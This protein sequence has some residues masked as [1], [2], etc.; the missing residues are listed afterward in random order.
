MTTILNK[1]KIKKPTLILIIVVVLLA[2]PGLGFVLWHQNAQT[3]ASATETGYKTAQVRRG[4]LTLS[5]TGSGTLAA[6]KQVNLAF[7]IAGKV[8]AVNVQV[9]DT[10]SAGEPLAGLEDVSSLD[11]GLATAEL[12]LKL[13]KRELEDL[14]TNG[15]AS[16][17]NAQL[18]LANAEKAV[19]DAKAAL[20]VKG[21]ARC[22]QKTI[23][24]YY[25]VYTRAVDHLNA[26]GDGGGSQD[27]YLSVIV[28]AKNQVSKAYTTYQYCAGF[29]DYEIDSSHANLTLAQATVQQ[30]KETL[31]VLQENGGVDPDQLAQAEYKVANA[32]AAY[33]DAKEKREGAALRA[34]FDGTVLSVAGQAG[35]EVGVDTFISLADLNHPEIDFS[36]D[37][38]DMDQ[39]SVGN[40]AMVV[41]DAM[42]SQTFNGRVVRVNPSLVT[43]GGYQVLQGVIELDLSAEKTTPR[44]L[45]GLSASVEIIGGEAKNAVLAPV[46]AIHDLGDDVYGVF[47][48]GQDGKLRL[49][50]VEVGLMDATYAEIKS[51]LSAGDIVSTGAMETK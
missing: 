26:L 21:M 36:V 48:I 17:A 23:D 39:V 40:R 12:D 38:T 19:I 8:A 1:Q 31:S 51:G 32:Q 44:F 20:K 49:K 46:E 7:P 15:T 42:P 24:A 2:V 43:T 47:A 34:P 3:T 18:T 5:A 37:E 45:V 50:V 29:T 33:D 13:A 28:P 22:D 10:V 9:G 16:L 30:A 27:Y 4:D 6:G 35:D 25:D 41:F 11:A 14:K